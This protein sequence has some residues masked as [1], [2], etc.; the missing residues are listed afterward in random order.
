MTHDE[1]DRYASRT[2]MQ[3]RS[4]EIARAV[5]VSGQ[6]MAQAAREAGVSHQTAREAVARILREY[7]ADGGYPMD[8]ETRTVTLPRDDMD[9]VRHIEDAALR[10]AGLRV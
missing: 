3:P 8:W 10:R 1:F 4:L 5:L 9:E 2:R 6:T 7:R